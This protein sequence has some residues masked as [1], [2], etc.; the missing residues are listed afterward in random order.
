[1]G[2]SSIY[3]TL[4]ADDMQGAVKS[5]NKVDMDTSRDL[6]FTIEKSQRNVFAAMVT[7]G[8]ATNNDIII[9]HPSVSKMHA[10]FK[11]GTENYTITDFGS[12]NGTYV[13]EWRLPVK[14]AQS[15]ENGL[16]IRFGKIETT[17]YEPEALFEYLKEVRSFQSITG[18]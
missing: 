8:R 13:K 18:A 2:Q 15:I 12:K 11:K 10:Y 9:N 16:V 5:A 1:M 7:V 6:L 17:F 3:A 4:A 14:E